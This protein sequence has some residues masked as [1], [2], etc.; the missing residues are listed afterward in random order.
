MARAFAHLERGQAP[1]AVE[2]LTP[3]LETSL[4]KED[5]LA[6][7]CSVAEA[8]LLLG[9]LSQASATLVSA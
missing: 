9:D 3:V 8:Y 6:I 5:E 1:A 7:R 2:L 4:K